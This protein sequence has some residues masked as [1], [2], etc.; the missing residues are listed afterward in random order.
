VDLKLR[1]GDTIRIA[2]APQNEEPAA[3]DYVELISLQ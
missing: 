2:G 3:L 1:A